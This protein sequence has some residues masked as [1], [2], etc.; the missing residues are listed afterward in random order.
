MSNR[1]GSL[2]RAVLLSFLPFFVLCGTSEAKDT[3]SGG[4]CAYTETVGRATI[5]SLNKAHPGDNNCEKNPVEVAFDFTPDD[6]LRANARTDKNKRLTV[7]DGRNPPREYVIGKGLAIGT[8]HRC[9]RK[10]ITKGT[11]TPLLFEF[12]SIDLSDFGAFCFS[13][14]PGRQKK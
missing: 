12:P 14:Q 2:A 9:I 10:S 3:V 5:L 13:M 6:P 1:A 4:A 11:C 8:T 7:G